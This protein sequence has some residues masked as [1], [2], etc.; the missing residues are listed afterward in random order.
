M[1][2]IQK[3]LQTDDGLGLLVAQPFLAKNLKEQ[4]QPKAEIK[5][6]ALSTGPR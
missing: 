5:R 1:R 2:R 3:V 6:E 4:D